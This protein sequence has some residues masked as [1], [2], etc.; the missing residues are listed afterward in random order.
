MENRHTAGVKNKSIDHAP[1]RSKITVLHQLCNL[2]PPHLV[3]KVARECGSG[4]HARTFS[5]WSHLVA[6]LHAQATHALGLND[7]CDSLRLHGGP[8][9][10]IR[11]ATPPARNTLSHANKTRPARIAQDVFWNLLA[12]LEKTHRGFGRT[13]RPR[14][15]H[16]F[17]Q[18]IS[19]LDSTVIELVAGSMDWAKHRRR[20][21]AAKAHVRLDLQ[22]LLP[23]C[24]VIDTAAEHDNRRA[25]QLTAALRPG[26]IVIADRGY[27]DQDHFKELDD[28]GV[29]WVTREKVNM[30]SDLLEEFP[31]P[32][33]GN[34]LQDQL[35]TLKK[36]LPV[37]RVTALVE[38]DGKEREMVFLTNNRQ[39]SANTVADLY[40]S[41]WEIEV[42]FK[43]LKQTFQVADFLGHSANAVRWQMWAALILML[44]LRFNAWL[45]DWNHSFLRLF[46]LARSCAWQKWDW[47]KLLKSCGTGGGSFRMLGAPQQ[48]F[49]P[50]FS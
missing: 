49:L 40:K 2:I 10:A 43:Q 46:A 11:G 22:T 24:V 23:R 50:G 36:G 7:V 25:A 39:W 19:I 29:W 1:T 31:V 45:S 35:V 3:P 9:S 32:A 18:T 17:R 26:E 14:R 20:K 37:R 12:H 41:R 13:G 5:H 44:L 16:R 27:V 48:A 38:V 6:L 8:L 33:G 21:A 30:V 42:F 4:S 15:L 28:R 47:A 34:I